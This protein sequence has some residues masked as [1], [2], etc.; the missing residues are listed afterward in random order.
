MDEHLIFVFL[1][2]KASFS[3]PEKDL[4]KLLSKEFIS[5]AILLM[6]FSLS[7][8]FYIDEESTLFRF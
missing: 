3:G 6:F 8:S 5:L 7:S 4:E 1:D 2:S